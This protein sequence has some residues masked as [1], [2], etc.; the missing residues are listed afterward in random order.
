[1][2]YVYQPRPLLTRA[3]EE[4]NFDSLVDSR[5]RNNYNQSEMSRMVACAAACVRHSARRRPRMSQV[6]RALEGDLS[7][8][9]LNERITPGHSTVYNSHE[10]SD[11]DSMR[12]KEDM[13]KFR[14]MALASQE[15]ASS[16]V[17]CPTSENALPLTS[18]KRR[19][20]RSVNDESGASTGRSVIEHIADQLVMQAVDRTVA[21]ARAHPDQFDL[22]PEQVNMLV[23]SMA[24]GVSNLPSDHP[25][26]MTTMREL[27]Q[28]MVSVLGDVYGSTR[29]PNNC[30]KGK[31]I[32]REDEHRSD[33]DDDGGQSPVRSRSRSGNR[34]GSLWIGGN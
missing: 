21:F 11:Y 24:E 1:M 15:Y 12:Y 13:K 2:L 25:L 22:A 34:N 5:L 23:Q 18:G 29:P 7:L 8:S 32:A 9:D 19:R 28:V 14:K 20:R 30:N 17:S 27:V 31:S 6:V 10:S 3:L 33:D 26:T 4:G 16:E